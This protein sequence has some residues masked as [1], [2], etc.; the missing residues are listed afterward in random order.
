MDA[1]KTG[2]LSELCLRLGRDGVLLR[3][4]SNIAWITDGADV[5]CDTAQATGVA[6]VLWT[7]RR[8]TVWTNTIEAPRP[9]AE[10]A[11]GSRWPARGLARPR[12]PGRDCAD[13]M[14]S[15]L[16]RVRR[17]VTEHEVAGA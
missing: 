1:T 10:E 13:A 4:R 15:F 14:Q 6:A 5:H 12:A 16:H 17:G 3:R 11:R 8:K 7:P 2:R 9:R